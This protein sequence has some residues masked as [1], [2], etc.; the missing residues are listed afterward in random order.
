M[1]LDREATPSAATTD[2]DEEGVM[3]GLPIPSDWD[4]VD[5][6]WMTG[7]LSRSFP[8]AVVG[9]VETLLRDDGTNR[10]ARLSLTY[11]AGAGPATVFVKA[12]DPAHAALN[13]ATGGVFNEARLFRSG[14]DLPVDH[15]AVHLALIDEERLDFCLV[16]EDVV[17]RGADPRDSTRP[18]SVEEAAAGVRAL[19]RLHGRFWGDRLE[20]DRRLDWVVPYRPWGGMAGGILRAIEKAGD[21]IPAEV[22][23]LDGER[24]VDDLWTRFVGSLTAGPST[25]VHGDAHIGNTYLLPDGEVGFLD[26]QVLRRS[27]PSVDLG[28]FLQGAVTVSDRRTAERDLLDEYLSALDLPAGER[29]DRDALWLAYRA[30]TVHGLALWLATFS[31]GAWQRPE[32]SLALV[33]RYAAAYVDLDAAA[34][35]DALAPPVG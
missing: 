27:G 29:P 3:D 16:M 28:Y 34:A 24:L 15:P 14:A 26:W 2:P 13:E 6:A 9:S 32:V 31:Y 1:A 21:A 4:D 7:A 22:R 18:Y 12:G 30:S 19:G 35:V 23:A 11:D 17:G 25:L 33:Q 8:G 5:P 20:A 10:R